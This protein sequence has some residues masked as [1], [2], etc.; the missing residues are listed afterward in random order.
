MS[1]I[2]T[3]HQRCMEHVDHQ[4]GM[5]SEGMLRARM[6]EEIEELRAELEKRTQWYLKVLKELARGDYE[7]SH[8]S[9]SRDMTVIFPRALYESRF[10]HPMDEHLLDL[11]ANDP[12]E[13]QVRAMTPQVDGLKENRR[14]IWRARLAQMRRVGIVI[15]E[16]K[17]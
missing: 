13:K 14:E 12:L 3:W 10:S 4:N 15:K 5:V 11:I 6:C 1:E 7:I 17:P 8:V 2:K 16:A 9:D